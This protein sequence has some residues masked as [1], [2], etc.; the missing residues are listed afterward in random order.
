MERRTDM[1]KLTVD[2]R[3]FTN[4]PEKK[5]R[6]P[7]VPQQQLYKIVYLVKL[8]LDHDVTHTHTHTHVTELTYT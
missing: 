4:A 2:V 8:P 3:N 5:N 6:L 7:S 1:T